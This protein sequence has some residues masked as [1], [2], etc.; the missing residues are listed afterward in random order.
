MQLGATPK[1]FL[2][3]L[4]RPRPTA[5]GGPPQVPL[6]SAQQQLGQQAY[7][8]AAPT[9]LPSGAL[10]GGRRAA[11]AGTGG[12]T[13]VSFPS[14]FGVRQTV[15][16]RRASDVSNSNA[17][18]PI[19]STFGIRT[20]QAEGIRS[21]SSEREREREQV[22][23]EEEEDH[24]VL[25]TMMVAGDAEVHTASPVAVEERSMETR[26]PPLALVIDEAHLSPI[27][28]EEPPSFST[29]TSSPPQP[30]SPMMHE[31]PHPHSPDASSLSPVLPSTFSRFD[32]DSSSTSAPSISTSTMSHSLPNSPDIIQSGFDAPRDHHRGQSN[33]ST[34][35]STPSSDPSI[36]PS[37]PPL[38]S[39]AALIPKSTSVLNRPRPRTPDSS[40][41][42]S[43]A[44]SYDPYSTSSLR[45]VSERTIES[46]FGSSSLLTSTK[47]KEEPRSEGAPMLELD[48]GMGG[49]ESM[50]DLASLLRVGSGETA[51]KRTSVVPPAIVVPVVAQ[52]SEVQ[53]AEQDHGEKASSPRTVT[54]KQPPKLD[55][56]Q[57]RSS[58]SMASCQPLGDRRRG[59]STSLLS[60]DGS[61]PQRRDAGSQSPV[62][63]RSTTPLPT[64]LPRSTSPGPGAFF[65]RVISSSNLSSSG[66][67]TLG[68]E[69][70][71]RRRSVVSLLSLKSGSNGDHRTMAAAQSTDSLAAPTSSKR[72]KVPHSLS[73]SSLSS[74]LLGSSIDKSLPPTP[75]SPST[76][77]DKSPV[78][79]PPTEDPRRPFSKLRKKSENGFSFISS[80]SRHKAQASTSSVVSER[81]STPLGRLFGSKSGAGSALVES[82]GNEEM[83]PMDAVPRRASGASVLGA[84]AALGLGMGI[85]GTRS[86]K[87]E[88]GLM[89]RYDDATI[90][91]EKEGQGRQSMDGLARERGIPRKSSTD[92]LLVRPIRPSSSAMAD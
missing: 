1:S 90:E 42:L 17:G 8:R 58:D 38:P 26:E 25:A 18:S 45:Y 23:E 91:Q 63:H 69:E 3:S 14:A 33:L 21:G 84:S 64:E 16:V 76:S 5:N 89:G 92:N 35:S 22:V 40:T 29:T 75:H 49:A 10:G 48:L 82:P 72:P 20:R 27:M 2:P 7:V 59:S 37:I 43:N 67:G 61:R 65:R 19:E 68:D 60:F 80:K 85:G 44:S 81:P 55:D 66:H 24:S 70:P 28:S 87:S 62:S 51:S 88:D 39:I 57:D 56:E 46:S 73:L 13:L 36:A 11:S 15:S 78:V 79:P 4:G 77:F 30:P 74:L 52:E 41:T 12:P 86:K 53:V 9:S 54:R 71:R 32:S 47:V 31:L 50:F 6:K 83:D 34:T